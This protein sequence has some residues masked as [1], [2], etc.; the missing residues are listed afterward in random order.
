[1][2]VDDKAAANLVHLCPPPVNTNHSAT[3]LMKYLSYL[4]LIF[5]FVANI[6]HTNPQQDMVFLV[7]EPCLFIVQPCWDT[8]AAT[9]NGNAH[10]QCLAWTILFL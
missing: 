1:M 7:S 5:S 10:Q 8:L 4:L 9:E 6:G 2:K 3:H